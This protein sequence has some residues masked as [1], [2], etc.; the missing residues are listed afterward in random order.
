MIITC[1]TVSELLTEHSED[2]LRGYQRA[3]V[4][5]HLK[6]CSRCRAHQ[7]QLESTVSVLH[8]IAPEAPPEDLMATLLDVAKRKLKD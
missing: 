5:M 2:T 8:A 7:K 3:R 1:R 4:R 6:L